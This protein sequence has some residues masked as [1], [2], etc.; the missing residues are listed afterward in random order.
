MSLT[1]SQVAG[2]PT[3]AYRIVESAFRARPSTRLGCQ[4]LDVKPQKGLG[5]SG[6]WAGCGDRSQSSEVTV[7]VATGPEGVSVATISL[8]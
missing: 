7:A 2:I 6:S 1:T 3:W 5:L 4:T 8:A